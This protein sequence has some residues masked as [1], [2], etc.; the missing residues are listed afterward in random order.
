MRAP[1][2]CRSLLLLF[3]LADGLAALPAIEAIQ[4][5]SDTVHRFGKFELTAEIRAAY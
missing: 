1:V 5:S 4:A 3:V 2:F